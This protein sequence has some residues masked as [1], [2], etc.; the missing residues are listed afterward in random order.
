LGDL[1]EIRKM[2]MEKSI[3]ELI[4]AGE[5]DQVCFV[6]NLDDRID[7]A[8]CIG[9]FSNGSGGSLIVGASKKGKVKGILPEKE[10]EQLKLILDNYC[11]SHVDVKVDQAVIKYKM[12]LRLSITECSE[13]PMVTIGEDLDK[14][15]WIR[16]GKDFVKVPKIIQHYWLAQKSFVPDSKLDSETEISIQDLVNTSIRLSHS[17][18]QSK[19]DGNHSNIEKALLSCLVNELIDFEFDGNQVYYLKKQEI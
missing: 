19:I 7:I 18:I 10:Q 12:V 5:S 4:Q 16:L 3:P 8:K 6:P 13:K 14:Q 11:L 15:C 2:F 17:Q 9:G 1:V